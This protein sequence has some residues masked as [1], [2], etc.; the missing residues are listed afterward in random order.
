MA[1]RVEQER[2]QFADREVS[3]SATSTVDMG[4]NFLEAPESQ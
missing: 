4:T 1:G 3:S 2:E